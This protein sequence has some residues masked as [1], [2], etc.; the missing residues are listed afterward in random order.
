VLKQNENKT[1][2]FASG[3][4]RDGSRGELLPRLSP[5]YEHRATVGDFRSFEFIAE[6]FRR[7]DPPLSS[8]LA[9][10]YADVTMSAMHA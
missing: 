5:R 2:R 4:S 8:Q 6:G 10:K 1:G 9:A 3:P 7:R